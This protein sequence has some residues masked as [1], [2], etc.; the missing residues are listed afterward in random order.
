MSNNFG[1]KLKL[2]RSSTGLSQQKFTDEIDIS[3]ASYKR[4]ETG[5]NDIPAAV[6]V[7]ILQHKDLSKFTLWLFTDK[8]APEAGQIAPGDKEL[9]EK[10]TDEQFETE[11]VKTSVDALMMFCHLDWFRPN[12]EKPV[13]FDDCGKLLL[14]DL[15]P[16][17]N[18]RF[19]NNVTSIKSA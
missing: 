9:H 14:K 17:I 12:L 11:F 8:T 4:Y 2:I 16:V 3:L 18:A 19:S 7:K 13:D 5:S 6:L 10:L 15:K 1:E